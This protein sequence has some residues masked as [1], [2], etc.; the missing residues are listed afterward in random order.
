MPDNRATCQ[1]YLQCSD[2]RLGRCQIS[3]LLL[4]SRQIT[5]SHAGLDRSVVTWDEYGAECLVC[6]FLLFWKESR[7][8]ESV[9]TWQPHSLQDEYRILCGNS[10]FEHFEYWSISVKILALRLSRATQG[11]SWESDVHPLGRPPQLRQLVATQEEDSFPILTA[12]INHHLT[13]RVCK[14]DMPTI[15]NFPRR[16]HYFCIRE[17]IDYMTRFDISNIIY[18]IVICIH[19]I[20]HTCYMAQN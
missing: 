8:Q 20:L 10:R 19:M 9:A 1:S 15:L 2:I 6:S 16:K 5:T 7:E 3:D 4:P 17:K 14:T 11:R 13:F 12:N 18:N